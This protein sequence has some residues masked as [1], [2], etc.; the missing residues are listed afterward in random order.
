MYRCQLLFGLRLAQ[1]QQLLAFLSRDS[2]TLA[3]NGG[4]ENIP[5]HCRD[6][7]HD[8][9][10]NKPDETILALG[11]ISNPQHMFSLIVGMNDNKILHSEALG[12][13]VMSIILA[14]I[15]LAIL[16]AYISDQKIEMQ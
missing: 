14:T 13:F 16:K 11:R 10:N 5:L 12:N 8:S 7:S 2:N 6:L 9:S 4:A 15:V 3:V 1:L